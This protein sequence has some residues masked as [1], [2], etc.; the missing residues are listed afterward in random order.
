MRRDGGLRSSAA[1]MLAGW[2]VGDSRGAASRTACCSAGVVSALEDL[3]AGALNRLEQEAAVLPWMTRHATGV[4][5]DDKCSRRSRPSRHTLGKF[6]QSDGS[7]RPSPEM[8]AA[9]S[10]RGRGGSKWKRCFHS[11]GDAAPAT[12]AWIG[13]RAPFCNVLPRTDLG[14]SPRARGSCIASMM[15]H[16]LPV[17][18]PSEIQHA[19]WLGAYAVA[20]KE[21]VGKGCGTT[22]P[23]PRAPAV[24]TRSS[25]TEWE[26]AGGPRPGWS[27]PP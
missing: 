7:S 3:R 6:S 2:C 25:R 9:S 26:R 4:A 21:P 16:A 1:A 14:L 11:G 15:L 17:L 8:T 10:A 20:M 18:E 23:C 24:L 13:R 22:T 19:W 27:S 5:A 12:R